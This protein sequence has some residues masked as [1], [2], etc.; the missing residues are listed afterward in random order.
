MTC[1]IQNF[2]W[3]YASCW[4][5]PPPSPP[6]YNNFLVRQFPEWIGSCLFNYF[7]L[8]VLTSCVSLAQM[9]L[10]ASWFLISWRIKT[11]T[12]PAAW[13]GWAQAPIV[14]H[15]YCHLQ[16]TLQL[17]TQWCCTQRRKFEKI[18][19]NWNRWE[20]METL[21]LRK[22]KYWKWYLGKWYCHEIGNRN[23]NFLQ[24]FKH[25]RRILLSLIRAN[26]NLHAARFRLQWELQWP[27][28][29]EAKYTCVAQKI[30]QS[31]HKYLK[32]GRP[33]LWNN[34]GKSRYVFFPL[35]IFSPKQNPGPNFLSELIPRYS[36]ISAWQYLLLPYRWRI[37]FS[38][39][40]WFLIN[41][42]IKTRTHHATFHCCLG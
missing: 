31:A 41:W 5:S 4:Y 7:C 8:A 23:R 34:I 38:G 13:D 21:I 30:W 10:W 40:P 22:L 39:P 33:G 2:I 9:G 27:F 12:H 35:P 29:R 32:H 16:P 37:F 28:F 6:W 14:F 15:N 26:L 19:K 42:T 11:R 1:D 36:T 20:K 3:P 17:V 24:V 18:L 25:I